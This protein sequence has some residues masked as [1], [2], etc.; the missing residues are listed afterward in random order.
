MA[1]EDIFME[2]AGSSPIDSQN[3]L[4]FNIPHT[5]KSFEDF[6]NE[7]ELLL[8]NLS[9]QNQNSSISGRRLQ[10]LKLR[11]FNRRLAHELIDKRKKLTELK[12]TVDS[13]NSKLMCLKFEKQHLLNEI[14]ACLSS[15]YHRMKTNNLMLLCFIGT[16]MNQSN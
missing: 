13:F 8:N 6:K 2:Y 14:K 10:V 4:K 9:E 5:A 16:F 11:Q 1:D 3:S 12:E 15:K 7:K